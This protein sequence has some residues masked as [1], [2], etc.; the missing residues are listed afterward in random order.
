LDILERQNARDVCVVVT[1]YF[2]GILLGTGGL[3]RAYGKAAAEEGLSA[4]RARGTE[5]RVSPV[6][7]SWIMTFT[8]G[9]EDLCGAGTDY[10]SGDAVFGER[11]RSRLKVLIPAEE[12]ESLTLLKQKSGK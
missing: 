12:Y 2:G 11:S 10:G 3:V 1:R 6:P 4:F 8:A 9:S 7:G 5:K